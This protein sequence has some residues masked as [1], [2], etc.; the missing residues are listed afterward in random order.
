MKPFWIYILSLIFFSS[1]KKST[2]NPAS[3]KLLW[4]IEKNQ[5]GLPGQTYVSYFSYDNSHRVTQASLYLVDSLGPSLDS[6][7]IQK[8]NYQYSDLSNNPAYVKWYYVPALPVTTYSLFESWK[9]YSNSRL[10]YDSTNL[11]GSSPPQ[12]APPELTYYTYPSGQIARKR[13]SGNT[14]LSID[15][16]FINSDNI[17]KSSL[18]QYNFWPGTGTND[19]M[20]YVFDD[21]I[22]PVAVPWIE[23]S[24][25]YTVLSNKN[26][27]TSAI[28]T[29]VNGWIRWVSQ[30]QY[31][32]DGY[33]VKQIENLSGSSPIFVQVNNIITYHYQ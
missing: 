13:Y 31:G 7:L 2:S 5:V 6:T 16:F 26:N 18:W 25:S 11:I 4:R 27:I 33:P 17:I 20:T 32:P 21:K 10:A 22:N 29:S 12:S 30:Y 19:V 24:H 1:C 9:Y 3:A 15:T 28:L 14:V 8:Y 23:Q